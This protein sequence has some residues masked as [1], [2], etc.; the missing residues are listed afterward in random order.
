M[1]STYLNKNEKVF[2]H[3]TVMHSILWH[4]IAYNIQ[5]HVQYIV[6]CSDALYKY[7]VCYILLLLLYIFIYHLE[8]IDST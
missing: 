5:I 8:S 4:V 2:M 1:I 7:N 6:H 3:A